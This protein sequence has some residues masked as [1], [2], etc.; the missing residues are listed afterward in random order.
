MASGYEKHACGAEPGGSWGNPRP[1]EN[2]LSG[3]AAILLFALMW[4]PT[5]WWLASMVIRAL[6]G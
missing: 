2:V 1:A 4:G 6:A 5:L 3:A